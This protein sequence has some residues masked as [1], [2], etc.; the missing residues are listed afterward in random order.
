[1]LRIDR[2]STRRKYAWGEMRERIRSRE[3]DI[4]VGTQILA[5]GHDFPHLALVGVLNAD[6][7]LYSADFRAAERLYALLT[8]VAGRAGTRRIAR[9]SPDPDRVSR[10]SGV[11]GAARPGLSPIRRSASRGTAADA[12]FRRSCIRRCCAPKH[13]KS[14]A[15]SSSSTTRGSSGGQSAATCSSSIP[16]LRPRAAGR[17]RACATARAVRLPSRSAGVPENVAG[18]AR[19]GKERACAVGAGSRSAGAVNAAQTLAYVFMEILIDA[20][21]FVCVAPLLRSPRTRRVV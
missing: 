6:S 7:M 15:R 20:E 3:V 9:R 5:K 8:Q 4:L 1:M 17:A 10:P 14:R 13:A 18:A 19:A 16:C 11:H 2:D 21:C 12:A